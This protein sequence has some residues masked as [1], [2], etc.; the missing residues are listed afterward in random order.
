[1][2]YSLVLGAALAV[3]IPT[4]TA[5]CANDGG[6]WYCDPVDSIKYTNFD[7]SGSYNMITN[8]DDGSMSCG[9]SPKQYSG[10]LAPL[11][12]EVS[13]HFRGPMNLHK[14]AVYNLGSDKPKRDL[15]PTIHERRHGHS[16]QRFHEKRAVG[17]VVTATIDGKVV[18]W[19]NNYGG[20]AAPTPAPGAPASGPHVKSYG[21][22][23]D[24]KKPK[25]SSSAPV[26]VGPGQW[27]RVAYY[28]ADAGEADG[29]TFLN[30]EGAWAEGVIQGFGCA[31]SYAAENLFGMGTSPSVP[32]DKMIPDGKEI[33][34]MTDKKCEGNSCGY[35]RPGAVAYHGFDGANKI[36]LAQLDMPLTG[37]KAES[38][39]S[40]VDMPAFWI[41]NA[42]IPRV[43]QYPM[44]KDCSCW[45]SGCGEFDVL[46][47]L[48]PGDK[49]CKSTLHGNVSGGSSYYFERPEKTVTA[50]VVFNAA[51]SSLHVKIL[52]DMKDFP[53]TLD[54]DLVK[55]MCADAERSNTF[56][57]GS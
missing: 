15:K 37:A 36:F 27:G 56:P 55:E 5:G 17:D 46:E 42:Q 41:L 29:I 38:I 22:P 31:L 23:K 50:A 18:T 34:I 28:D 35:S 39:Y 16:H 49:R 53:T 14:L 8:M 57:L 24:N 51:S 26:N 30:N 19:A 13:L 43:S 54:A 9:S 7:F 33:V 1:M 48:A 47:V 32:K 44:N 20:G 2:Q 12:E 11:D 40:P 52:K 3:A 25:P 45:A 6:N 10:P 21:A 4:V